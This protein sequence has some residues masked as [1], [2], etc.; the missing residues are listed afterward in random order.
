MI[1]AF[2][3]PGFES[4]R[5]HNEVEAGRNGCAGENASLLAIFV[6]A[7]IEFRR[8]FRLHFIAAPPREGSASLAKA[9]AKDSAANPTYLHINLSA[10][11]KMQ[12]CLQFALAQ[13]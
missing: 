1:V 5:L 2:S 13:S 12:A 6:S 4:P 8:N 9:K 3:G 7:V 11:E 10:Q